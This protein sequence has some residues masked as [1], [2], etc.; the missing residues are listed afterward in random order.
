MATIEVFP[1]FDSVERVLEGA[2]CVGLMTGL[3]RCRFESGLVAATVM[4]GM[5]MTGV[6]ED[7]WVNM[8]LWGL[9]AVSVDEAGRRL[10]R[11]LTHAV[12]KIPLF[13]AWVCI[14]FTPRVAMILTALYAV[15][16]DLATCAAIW[17]CVV[18]SLFSSTHNSS[19][20]LPVTL[21]LADGVPSLVAHLY[22]NQSSM[23][24]AMK[25]RL[26]KACSAF[27]IF[28]MLTVS[29]THAVSSTSSL[30]F[31]V[32]GFVLMSHVHTLLLHKRYSAQNISP[33]VPVHQHPVKPVAS[34]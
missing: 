6:V 11:D 7:Q 16:G 32:G 1:E 8:L 30:S 5:V 24:V 19:A 4:A 26:A 3:A 12:M 33:S 29:V 31:M 28:L 25:T 22:R 20:L 34:Y 18:R 21:L 13:A 2:A 15:E 23:P 17:A 9:L 14:G 10:G 27:S